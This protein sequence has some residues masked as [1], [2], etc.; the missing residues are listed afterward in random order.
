MI[1]DGGPRPVHHAQL[2]DGLED[3]LGILEPFEIQHVARQLRDAGA[4][5]QHLVDG[6]GITT[7]AGELGQVV[8]D[9]VAET[10][11]AALGQ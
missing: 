8:D 1:R 9:P 2:R 11:Y 5:R 6:D 4:V 10:Q 7:A 3:A